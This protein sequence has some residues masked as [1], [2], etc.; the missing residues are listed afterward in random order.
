MA[1]VVADRV[2]QTSTTSGTGTLDLSASAAEGFQTFVQG[3]GDGNETYYAIVD[4]S[5]FEV[6]IGTVT[7]AATDTLSRDT[8]LT[9]TN[10]GNKVNFSSG[11]KDVFC[12]LPAKAQVRTW[13]T[14]TSA[15][16]A[17]ANENYFVNTSS[18]AV[19]ATLPASP[20]VGDEIRFIDLSGTFDTNNL[21]LG[22]NGNNINGEASDLTVATER[23]GF[24]V[25]FSGATQ[26]WLIRD[27]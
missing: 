16:N 7:D 11:E 2:K 25:V 23:A 5:D 12:T 1:L 27:K 22:R 24:A 15:F 10:S 21:T 19:T 9:S 6:G 17:E 18:A 26:G 14:K 20:E 13:E 8:V 4:G 3:V